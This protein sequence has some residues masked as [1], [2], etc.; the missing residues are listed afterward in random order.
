MYFGGDVISF[1]IVPGLW[2][3]GPDHWQSRWQR[4]H[5]DWRRVEQRD[6]QTPQPTD[7]IAALDAAITACEHAPVLVAHSLACPTLA[8]WAVTATS[9]RV[10]GAFLVAPC[11]VDAANRPPAIAPFAPMPQ[12]RLPF[13][14]LVVASDDDPF[15]TPQR[16]REFAASWGSQFVLL[17]RA[18]HIN[19]ESGYG[20]WP[21]GEQLLDAFV[22]TLAR[23]GAV[24]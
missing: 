2:N 11:D 15:A 6:W 24:L 23:D 14:S 9:H 10:A 5:G 13:A 1:L 8:H 17:D 12:A 21:G 3:S 7:W 18:G 4:K 22:H 19:A 16:S 20:D